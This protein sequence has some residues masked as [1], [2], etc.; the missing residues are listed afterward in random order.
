MPCYR[1]LKGYRSRLVNPDSG[2]PIITFNPRKADRFNPD[3]KLS[4]PCGQCV[5]CRLEKSRRW[6]IRCMHEASLHKK[7]S[8]ITL[9]YSPQNLPPNGSLVLSHFQDFMKRL[10]KKYGSGIRFFHC[11]EYGEKNSRPHYHALLFGFDFPDKFFHRKTKLGHTI[12]R[13]HSLEKLWTFGHSEIG[14]VT[15]E[16]AAYCARYITKKITNKK[17]HTDKNGQYWPAA[18]EHYDGKKPEYTTMSRRP[19]L[20]HG[21]FEKHSS[22]VYPSDEVVIVRKD[23]FTVC[24][25][26]PYYDRLYEAQSPDDFAAIKLQRK[27]AAEAAGILEDLRE[28]LPLDAKGRAKCT[29]ACGK[30]LYFAPSRRMIKEEVKKLKFKL[31]IRGYEKNEA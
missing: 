9:T 29:D 8:F 7:N 5:G 2:K 14:A 1:P 6:A 10:R 28:S 19:G 11:G 20:A 17:A 26:P 4:I 13:S 18:A 23:K 24:K 3:N 12:W 21:W 30:P 16:S 27:A 25:P 15:F 31:L 22:D